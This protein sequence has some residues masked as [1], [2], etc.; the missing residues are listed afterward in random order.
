MKTKITT[1]NMTLS[2]SKVKAAKWTITAKSV[3]GFESL[4]AVIGRIGYGVKKRHPNLAALTATDGSNRLT[5]Q[6]QDIINVIDLNEDTILY[7]DVPSDDEII[8]VGQFPTRQHNN[9]IRLS[10]DT[11]SRQLTLTMKC[12]STLVSLLSP[13]SRSYLY[14]QNMVTGTVFV[15][16][17]NRVWKV[18][19][20]NRE[21]NH[22]L[23]CDPD[24]AAD[25]MWVHN[26][27]VEEN[28]IVD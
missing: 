10:Y 23:L 28:E 6:E 25:T 1:D 20:V 16:I 2:I 14:N 18:S 12:Y 7:R 27:V 9:F 15:L 4:R 24:N 19:R 21:N 8:H 26:D 17:N 13:D 22:S 3:E 11:V 5:V